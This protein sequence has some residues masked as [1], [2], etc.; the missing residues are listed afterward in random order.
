MINGVARPEW[1]PDWT[2]E[3]VAIV[4]AGPSVKKEEVE[5]LK[6]RIHVIAINQSYKLCPWAEFLYGCDNMWWRISG[7]EAKDFSGIKI[8]QD[9]EALAFD[10][11]LKKITIKKINKGEYTH[12]IQMDEPGVVGSGG[13]AGF[14][15]INLSAQFGVKGI[16]LIGFDFCLHSGKVHWHGSHPSPLNNPY[17]ANFKNWIPKMIVASAKLKLM[18]IDVVNCSEISALTCFPKMSVEDA[19]RR[20]SL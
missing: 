10:N 4:A 12:D 5:L 3:C 20:W 19:L 14:Q 7:K 13:N 17:D 2:D 8:S 11:S 6:D 9:P 16:A 15:M 1:F 18:G